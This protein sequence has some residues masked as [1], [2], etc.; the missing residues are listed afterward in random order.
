MRTL[1][2]GKRRRIT[3]PIMRQ[4]GIVP[5]PFLESQELEPS[6]LSPETKISPSGTTVSTSPEVYSLGPSVSEV[7]HP[8]S[9][10]KPSGCSSL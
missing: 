3:G 5:R 8:A 7:R 9:Y 2:K 4:Y 10:I 6:R 1:S